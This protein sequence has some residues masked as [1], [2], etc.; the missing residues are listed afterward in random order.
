MLRGIKASTKPISTHWEVWGYSHSLRNTITWTVFQSDFWNFSLHQRAPGQQLST[1]HHLTKKT[2]AY[3]S[4]WS[5]RS[6]PPPPV[7]T[8]LEQPSLC[9]IFSLKLYEALPS[10]L[11]P[12]LKHGK[13]G[14][15]VQGASVA[16]G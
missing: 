14:P 12:S 5:Q 8:N 15:R 3:S 11:S 4:F 1:L 16:G 6:R 13:S 7:P 10:V 9:H 2:S